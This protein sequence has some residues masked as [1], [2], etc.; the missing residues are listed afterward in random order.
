MRVF[1]RNSSLVDEFH[2]PV[3]VLVAA[4]RA[5]GARATRAVRATRARESSAAAPVAEVTVATPENKLAT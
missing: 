1:C 3:P 4:L 2:R 5:V